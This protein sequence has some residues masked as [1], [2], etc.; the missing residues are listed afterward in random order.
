MELEKPYLPRELRQGLESQSLSD[1]YKRQ[2]LHNSYEEAKRLIGSHREALDKIAA[3]L[4]RRETI[5]GKEFMK[6]CV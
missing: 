6:R 4:I 1:V 5:T 3:Y 2:L